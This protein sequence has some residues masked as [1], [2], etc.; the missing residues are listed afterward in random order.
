MCVFVVYVRCKNA[1]IVTSDN[2]VQTL[3]KPFS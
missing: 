3:I 2:N 1:R